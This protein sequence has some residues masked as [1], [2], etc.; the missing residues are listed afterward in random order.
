MSY[1]PTAGLEIGFFSPTLFVPV[2][3]QRKRDRAF[4]DPKASDHSNIIPDSRGRAR[5]QPLL[6]KRFL[7]E[8][9]AY[10][11]ASSSHVAARWQTQSLLG[12]QAER[13]SSAFFVLSLLR[14]NCQDAMQ[15][16]DRPCESCDAALLL[17]SMERLDYSLSL[18]LLSL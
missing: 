3:T 6:K 8:A 15:L 2:V 10:N 16:R 18:R 9:S 14:P 1:E 13:V 17:F 4:S 7:P 12:C 5:S 11:V